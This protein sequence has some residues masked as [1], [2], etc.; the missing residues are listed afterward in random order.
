MTTPT[1]KH[2]CLLRVVVSHLCTRMRHSPGTMPLFVFQS[3]G[4]F[5]EQTMDAPSGAG[6]PGLICS[7]EI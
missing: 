1:C 3:N 4:E 2:T 6:V 5:W 7:I